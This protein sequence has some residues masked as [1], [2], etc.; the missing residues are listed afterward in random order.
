M[1][2]TRCETLF[3]RFCFLFLCSILL[4]MQIVHY[5]VHWVAIGHA[6]GFSLSILLLWWGNPT[7][8]AGKQLAIKIENYCTS[9]MASNCSHHERDKDDDNNSGVAYF[10]WWDLTG[11][12]WSRTAWW[13]WRRWWWWW[14]CFDDENGGDEDQNDGQDHDSD[15]DGGDP[16]DDDPD[17]DI[18]WSCSLTLCAL[19]SDQIGWWGSGSAGPVERER[20]RVAIPQFSSATNHLYMCSLKKIKKNLLKKK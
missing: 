16:D 12:N 19:L 7:C 10:I 6:S 15:P 18:A 3:S 5:L 20:G 14:N 17:D 9:S 4:L 8:P 13:W 1:K 2:M 11:K